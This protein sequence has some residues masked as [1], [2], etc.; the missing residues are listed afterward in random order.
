MSNAGAALASVTALRIDWTAVEQL[1]QA[2]I[3]RIWRINRSS[4][5]VFPRPNMHVVIVPAEGAALELREAKRSN[6][7]FEGK[8]P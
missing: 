6:A 4:L 1:Y 5:E 2:H 7:I 3:M 8:L